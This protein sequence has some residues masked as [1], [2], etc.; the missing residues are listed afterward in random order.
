MVMQMVGQN[1]QLGDLEAECRESLSTDGGGDASSLECS[2]AN[3]MGIVLECSQE[4]AADSMF[5][6]SPCFS[7]LAPWYEVCQ[8]EIP[9]YMQAMMEVPISLMQQCDDDAPAAAVC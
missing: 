5:C 3:A 7:V 8:A 9:T 4:T 1:L 2:A 6:D